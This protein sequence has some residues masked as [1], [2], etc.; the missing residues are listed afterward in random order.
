MGTAAG[1]LD[2]RKYPNRRYY[3]AT[4]SRHL[5]LEEIRNLI[6]QG[7]DITVTESASGMDI[8]PQV[9]TQIILEF[10]TPKLA[11]FSV[12]LL[13][14]MIRANDELLREFTAKYFDQALQAYLQYQTQMAER[15][16][17]AQQLTSPFAAWT[18]AMT[19]PFAAG[20]NPRPTP[21]S[22]PAPTKNPQGINDALAELRSQVAELQEELRKAKSKAGKR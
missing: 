22:N 9:L 19:A 10:E 15:F 2:I 8:T 14:R 1:H 7:C 20:F 11:T 6:H 16:R 13:L 18:Q 3:D 4:N 17:E 21:A 12:P 5:T